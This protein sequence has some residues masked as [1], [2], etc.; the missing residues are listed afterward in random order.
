MRFFVSETGQQPTEARKAGTAGRVTEEE[1]ARPVDASV[2]RQ[3]EEEA[4]EDRG[5]RLVQ[6]KIAFLVVVVVVVVVVGG[7]REMTA[8]GDDRFMKEVEREEVCREVQV[9]AP[10]VERCQCRVLAQ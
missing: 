7:K 5:G 8:T 3:S 1:G 9:E 6:D 10:V 2:E 4:R